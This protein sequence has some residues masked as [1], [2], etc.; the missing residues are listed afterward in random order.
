[1]LDTLRWLHLVYHNVP[2][3]WNHFKQQFRAKFTDFTKELQARNQLK[4]LK[5]RYPDIDGYIAEFED[6]IV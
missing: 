3:V 5:F 2:V 1:M 4:K 6:L